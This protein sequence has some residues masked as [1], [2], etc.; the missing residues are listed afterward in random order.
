M[1]RD[2]QVKAYLAL[3]ANCIQLAQEANDKQS[4]L[5]LLDLA[6]GWL[7]IAEGEI[8][9]SDAGGDQR[10]ARHAKEA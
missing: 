3:A 5:S 10:G 6:R 2:R 4:R 1:T 9:S 8:G 7:A